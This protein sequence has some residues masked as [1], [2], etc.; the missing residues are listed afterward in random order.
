[1]LLLRSILYVPGNSEKMISKIPGIRADVITLDLEDA[2]STAEKENARKMSSEFL[3]SENSRNKTIYVRV[4]SWPTGLTNDDC[5]AIVGDGLDAVALPKCNGPN[6]VIRLDWKLE[7]LEQRNRLEK[8]SI[9]IQVLIEN[10][11]GMMNA[12]ASAQA[13]NRVNSLIFGA[14]DYTTDMRI[15]LNQPLGEG[16]KWARA[17]V[18]CAARAAG[19]LAIDSPYVAYKDIEGFELD[20]KYGRDLGYEG[21]MLIHPSQ[22]EPSHKIYSPEPEK[23]IWAKEVVKAFEEDGISKGIAS[24]TYNG[25]MIDT[26]VY[27]G[28]K[29]II[30]MMETI[31][32]IEKNCNV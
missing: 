9:K 14:V 6:D 31:E 16:L 19:L 2:V 23:V 25:Q 27:I 26:P 29:N 22:I 30:K 7:E 5:E 11:K 8:G 13:S 3:K 1:M 32:E 20:T 21:R 17:R 10:A 24:I 28:A 4:N 12:Y 15:S 18:A